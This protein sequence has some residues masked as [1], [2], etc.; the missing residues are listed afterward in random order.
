MGWVVM[1][2]YCAR[3]PVPA[4]PRQA[5]AD[6]RRLWAFCLASIADL[7]IESERLQCHSGARYYR[8]SPLQSSIWEWQMPKYWELSP[9]T[10]MLYGSAPLL[11]INWRKSRP[12]DWLLLLV[13]SAS[14]LMATRNIFLIGL[15]GPML[16]ATY[17]PQWEDRTNDFVGAAALAVILAAIVAL[18]PQLPLHD[19]GGGDLAAAA[20]AV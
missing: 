4:L 13:F 14:G 15:W 2:A 5:A 9:F 1:G 7:G 11:L 12:V 6:E 18:L 20:A 8:Q 10:I 3:K 19:C 16:I 17:P